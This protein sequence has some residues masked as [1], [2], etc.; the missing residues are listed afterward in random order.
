MEIKKI[1]V[2]LVN[3]NGKKFLKKCIESIY[4]QTYK[5]ILILI[6]DNNSTDGSVQWLAVNYP[7]I[8]V[9]ACKKNYGFSKGNNIGISYAMGHGADYILLLNV[10]TVIGQSM[11]GYL[12][13]YA[14]N[15]TVT[16]PKI[17]SDKN[18]KKIWYAGG[19]MD[20][21]NGRS[22][23]KIQNR[24]NIDEVT[25][26]CGCC[27]L[28]H[29]DIIAKVGM[30]NEKYYLYFEDTDFSIRLDKNNI[31]IK[32]IPKAEMWHRIG[33]SGGKNGSY[34]KSYYM[35]RNQLY[36]I[37]KYKK[38]MHITVL[39]KT[40]EIFWKDIL[41]ETDRKRRKYILWGIWD[42]YRGN[43]SKLNH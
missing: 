18:M 27:M 25:F 19:V 8:K 33:G 17:Y 20:F 41:H 39:K 7:E 30:L 40:M 43:M 3:Y 22:Y 31:K 23:H 21:S 9:I 26:A 12:L 1:T 35:T 13:E 10:D 28:I 5:N 11:I 6:V 4:N 38:D 2:V 16:V 24:G 29:K 36:F 34:I 42:F 14:N 37:L 15:T 32:Y